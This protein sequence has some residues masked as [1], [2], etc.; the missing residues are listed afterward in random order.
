MFAAFLSAVG[1]LVLLD[2]GITTR[3]DSNWWAA[4]GGWIGGIGS[5]AAAAA[6]VWVAVEGWRRSDRDAKA[7]QE[8]ELASKVAIW[9]EQT[10]VEQLP[11]AAS[12]AGQRPRTF[13]R[14]ML[15]YV[16]GGGMPI[17][18]AEATVTYPNG[19]VQYNETQLMLRPTVIPED[20]DRNPETFH[21]I[22]EAALAKEQRLLRAELMDSGLD[23]PPHGITPILLDERCSVEAMLMIISMASIRFAFTDAN[24]VRWV[25]EPDGRLHRA[26]AADDERL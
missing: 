22:L 3:R 8:R 16:N 14:F 19:P 21:G 17:Y 20:F 7:K 15:R 1:F 5:A 4:W 2:I 6:A 26:E 11:R 12:L 10:E 23:D 13:V 9:V 24:R 18:N 25:R